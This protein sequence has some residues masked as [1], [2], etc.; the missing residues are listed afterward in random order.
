MPSLPDAHWSIERFLARLSSRSPVPGGG[1]AAALACALGCALA[2]KVGKILLAR[3]RLPDSARGKI[4]RDVAFFDAGQEKMS[5]L[6]HEDARVY[7]R[8]VRAQREGK[9]LAAFK[10]EAIQVPLS[11][12]GVADQAMKRLVP[13]VPLAGR[14]LGSDLKAARALLMA[15]SRAAAEM[16]KVNRQGES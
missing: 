4:E 8:F 2:A 14:H 13:L 12:C 7:E 3:P 5:C 10:R 9:G 6:I 11:L 1:S 15:G 16:V